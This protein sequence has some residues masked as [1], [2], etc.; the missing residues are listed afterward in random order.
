MATKDDDPRKPP[1]EWEK[2][3]E[4]PNI[5][6]FQTWGGHTLIFDNTPGNETIRMS[7][8][9]S[10]NPG[11]YIEWSVN[12][13]K[14]EAVRDNSFNY[15]KGGTTSTTDKGSDSKTGGHSRTNVDGGSHSETA[16]DTSS[17][18]KATV[19]AIAKGVENK[20]VVNASP[21]GDSDQVTQG[22]IN[23][24]HAGDHH[25]TVEGDNVDYTDGTRIIST[26]GEAFEDVQGGNKSVVVSGTLKLQ[27]DTSIILEV[28]SSQIIINPSDIT[29]KV[30]SKGIKID[31]SDVVLT[32][33]TWVG[34]PSLTSKTGPDSPPFH[35]P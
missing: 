35:S 29:I 4:Y 16:K 18:I 15:T 21:G 11:S 34:Q 27:S 12:G 20:F 2:K 23:K 26:K 25:V 24:K 32:G 3:A 13:K 31:S 14:T 7:H 10:E 5:Q 17:A 28:G 9:G 6:S 22:N 30:G 33:T 19:T 8:G 1:S